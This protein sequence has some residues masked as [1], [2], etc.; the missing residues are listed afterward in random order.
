MDT[1]RG[2]TSKL[3]V[4]VHARILQPHELIQDANVADGE[5]LILEWRI[6]INL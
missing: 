1:I 5:Q 4:Q 3:P 6:N 2:D